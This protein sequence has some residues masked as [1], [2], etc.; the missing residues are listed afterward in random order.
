MAVLF[1]Y[2]SV[3]WHNSVGH[4]SIPPPVP[5][6]QVYRV[7]MSLQRNLQETVGE[8]ISVK[9]AKDFVGS[10]DALF[11]TIMVIVFKEHVHGL[12]VCGS[13]GYH[14]ALLCLAALWLSLP[15]S[16]TRAQNNAQD[17]ENPKNTMSVQSVESSP[18]DD[19]FM[20]WER[21]AAVDTLLHINVG[22]S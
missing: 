11:S 9:D 4:S 10:D 6:E 20:V 8:L 7:G 13:V 2:S 14:L 5:H 16:A 21:M 3:L 12:A 22:I 19:T 15:V 18:R 1:W 17:D